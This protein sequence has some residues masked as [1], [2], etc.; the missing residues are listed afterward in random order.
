MAPAP[1]NPYKD[2]YANPNGVGDGR[3]TAVQ[4]LIDNGS[5]GAYA[6]KVALITGGTN[7]IGLEAVRAL[8]ATE[9]DIYFTARSAEKAEKVR[10]EILANSNGKGKLEVVIMNMDSLQ[11]VRNAAK[12]FLSRSSKINIII[13]NSGEL[14]A[15]RHHK[16]A[17]SLPLRVRR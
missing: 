16:Q 14:K 17:P 1:M 2:A 6:G 9:A 3:P 7:G 10:R 13:Y 4:V 11:S 15:Y 5:V 8:R 12:S